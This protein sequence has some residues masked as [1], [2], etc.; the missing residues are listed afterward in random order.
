MKFSFYNN[1]LFFGFSRVPHWRHLETWNP[2]TE[3]GNEIRTGIRI[4][5]G[6]IGIP[7][8]RPNATPHNENYVVPLFKDICK[9]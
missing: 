4:G 7:S 1:K 3:F 6:M 9:L 8:D 5:T 2:E